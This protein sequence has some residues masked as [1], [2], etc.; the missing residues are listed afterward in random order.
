MEMSSYE[1]ACAVKR[2]R[3]VGRCGNN[4]TQGVPVLR[5]ECAVV[6][7]IKRWWMIASA[8]GCRWNSGRCSIQDGDSMLGHLS[9]AEL[10]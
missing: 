4:P 3:V 10:G 7:D 2:R 5:A 9:F 8:P 6:V 1:M